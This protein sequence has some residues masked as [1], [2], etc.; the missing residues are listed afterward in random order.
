M[1]STAFAPLARVVAEGI[2]QS[3]LPIVVVPH[4]VADRD[5]ELVRSRGAEIAA[6][7][8]RVLTTPAGD[9]EREFG[10]KRYPLPA[11]VMPR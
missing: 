9:L 11:A 2:G 6:D 10:N 4:P 3:S 8:V 5:L 7:C 1:I